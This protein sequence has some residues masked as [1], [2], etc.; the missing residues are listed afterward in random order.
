MVPRSRFVNPW[1]NAQKVMRPTGAETSSSPESDSSSLSVS[2]TNELTLSFLRLSAFSYRI[3]R[4]VYQTFPCVPERSSTP[5]YLC[6]CCWVHRQVHFGKICSL[7]SCDPRR[8]ESTPRRTTPLSY[9]HGRPALEMA[10]SSLK[11]PSGSV[12]ADGLCPSI[13]RWRGSI[14]WPTL[15]VFAQELES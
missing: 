2:M 7:A 9:D 14:P 5:C 8:S 13:E 10:V 4:D 12:I 15:W 6:L 1:L 3:W 11:V